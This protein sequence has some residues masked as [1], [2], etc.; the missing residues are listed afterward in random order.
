M[1]ENITPLEDEHLIYRLSQTPY[2]P[3]KLY[4][5]GELSGGRPEGP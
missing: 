5:K 3:E 4:V 2:P 1:Q